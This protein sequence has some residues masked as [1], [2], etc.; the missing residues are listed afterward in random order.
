R[1]AAMT[2]DVATPGFVE[3]MK[4][5]RDGRPLVAVLA[6]NA[7]T[8]MTDLLLPHAVLQ[9]SGAVDVQIVAPRRGAVTLYPALQ[10]DGAQD[11]AAFDRAHP[12]GPDYVIVP[13]MQPNDDAEV[14]RWLRAQA[15]RGARVIGVC[16]GA[17]VVARAGL[18]D[19]HRF[20]THWYY[21]GQ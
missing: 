11:F 12:A 9:R 18:L 13:A 6:S 1:V 17:L 20:T 19:G 4:P 21:R 3:A 5:R 7:G 14:T 2:D 15:A 10:V 16:A 8:E